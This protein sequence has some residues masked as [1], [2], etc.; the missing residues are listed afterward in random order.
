MS[1][2]QAIF[3]DELGRKKVVLL[4]EEAPIEDTAKGIPLGPPNLDELGLPE[5]TAV[6]LHNE[7]FNRGVIKQADA[8]RGR[9]D[10][11]GALQSAFKVDVERI[12]N[13]YLGAD[14][15]TAKPE[16]QAAVESKVQIPANRNRRRR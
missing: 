3:T 9:A 6:R 13:I 8:L 16:K 12:M 7:L 11:M 5:E 1:L 15:R 14:Y 2:K 10:I 4:P